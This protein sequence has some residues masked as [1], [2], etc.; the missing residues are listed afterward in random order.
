MITR[1]TSLVA[2][3]VLILSPVL[4]G[5]AQQD[6]RQG[7]GGFTGELKPVLY[8]SDVE[9]SARFYRDVLGFEFD[10]YANADGGPYYAEMVAAGR[11]FG[12]HEPIAA[13]QEERVGR[14]RLYFR[15]RDLRV[16]HARV[17]AWGGE[18]GAIRTTDWMDMFSVLD[19]D[20]NEITFAFT[21]PARHS[22]DPWRTG[23][24]AA[25]G[26]ADRP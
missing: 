24:E 14:Q 3:A 2:V 5:R 21:D 25:R 26:N 15:V 4:S 20:G 13:G 12:L 22:I 16:H 19:P 23:D 9:R 10:G 8:V 6:A 1:S 17:A 11:K 7:H 18:P